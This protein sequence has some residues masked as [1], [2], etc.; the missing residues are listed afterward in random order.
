MVPG[1]TDQRI[2]GPLLL[3]AASASLAVLR[4]DRGVSPVVKLQLRQ[5]TQ[6][7]RE[8]VS[9]NGTRRDAVEKAAASL[10]GCLEI[11]RN[12]MTIAED[13]KLLDGIA[14]V[15]AYLT[16]FLGGPAAPIAEALPTTPAARPNSAPPLPATVVL[17]E[18]AEPEGPFGA[19]PSESPLA[20]PATLRRGSQPI[21][22]TVVVD[23]DSDDSSPL[24]P[25]MPG[26]A[27][28]TAKPRIAIAPDALSPMLALQLVR[29]ERLYLA[30]AACIDEPSSTFAD[31]QALEGRLRKQEAATAELLLTEASTQRA[32]HATSDVSSIGAWWILGEAGQLEA[33]SLALATTLATI[34]GGPV[35]NQRLALDVLR[36]NPSYASTTD[37]WSVLRG[38]A[39]MPLR[40]RCLPLLFEGHL[41]DGEALV[42]MLDEAA[43]AIPAAAALAWCRIQDGSRR[44][45]EK[46]LACPS[47]ELSEALLFASVTQ[48]DREALSEIRI[49]LTSGSASRW[50]IDGLAVAGDDT[51]A[52]L[53]LDGVTS[54]GLP[55]EYAVWALAHLGASTALSRMQEL[56][57]RLHPT[58]VDRAIAL[59][60]G[61]H[62]PSTLRPGRYLDGQPWS[63]A[64]VARRLARPT[65]LPLPLL[66]WSALDLSVRTGEAAPCIYDIGSATEHQQ[67]AAQAFATSYAACLRSPAGDWYYFGRSLGI[68]CLGMP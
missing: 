4:G 41:P 17:P 64:A 46:A 9:S 34:A 61:G 23:P 59:I 48:G 53:L 21:P 24:L 50:L 38:P 5:A 3:K 19:P 16:Q 11:V 1:G 66:R 28:A 57:R 13:Q 8:A 68:A 36:L 49:R 58:L 37:I 15:L 29:I 32:G 67:V 31:L 10:R 60:A 45:L 14:A 47:P 2:P 12:G 42:R 35:Q 56:K 63:A 65:D 39:L 26:A 55:A 62:A 22:T 51:D 20:A 7:L 30:R 27:P 18:A 33:G 44:L 40:A 43:M 52:Q 6:D 54:G 25:A